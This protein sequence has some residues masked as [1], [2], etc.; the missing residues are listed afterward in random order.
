M[1]NDRIMLS[2][3][4]MEQAARQTDLIYK[5]I[6]GENRLAD[7]YLPAPTDRPPPLVIFI[8]GG[9][10][11]GMEAKGHGHFISWG[12]LIAA[13]GMAALV[14]NHR[15]RWMGAYIPDSLPQA[16]EDLS[17]AVAYVRSNAARLKIDASRI[18]FFAFSAGGPL[19]AAPLRER[20]PGI[21]CVVAFYTVLGEP[22]PGSTDAGR[23][24]AVAG[25]ADGG[26]PPPTFI[27]KA[28]K[29]FMPLINSSLDEFAKIAR[30]FG[31]EVRLEEHPAG[32]HGFDGRND[33]ETSRA[34][35]RHA[36]EFIQTHLRQTS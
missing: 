20:W 34:I 36:I 26:K 8:H 31:A 2:I 3:P 25:L 35:M 10:P 15:A 32:E 27:A 28:G 17:D 11:P 29:E 19:L 14:F 6:G 7:L 1:A 4:G 16:A 22:L 21:R 9:L 18:C 12:E 23:F 5:T 13:S 30:G 24:S 33:D